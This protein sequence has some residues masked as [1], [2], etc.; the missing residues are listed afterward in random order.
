MNH[1][2]LNLVMARHVSHPMQSRLPALLQAK[3][4]GPLESNLARLAQRRELYA[5]NKFALRLL[6][7]ARV[8]GYRLAHL[9]IDDD[10]A[11]HV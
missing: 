8:G 3:K 11:D 1:K 5:V 10:G 4:K 2:V 6:T 7:E 9:R